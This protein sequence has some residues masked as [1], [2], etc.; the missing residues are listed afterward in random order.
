MMNN[1]KQSFLDGWK[2][3]WKSRL[4]WIAIGAFV[5]IYDATC[6]KGETLSEEV[7]RQRESKLGRF[8][9]DKLMLD[10]TQHLQGQENWINDIAKLNPKSQ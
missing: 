5:T 3:H 8:I 9:I 1:E 7:Y 4:A 2:Q 6:P 10:T